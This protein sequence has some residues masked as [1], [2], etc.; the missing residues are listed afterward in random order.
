MVRLRGGTSPSP[1][2][3]SEGDILANVWFRLYSEF[4]SDPKVRTMT[5]SQQLILVRLFCLRCDCPTEKLSDEEIMFGVGCDPSVFQE[6]KRVFLEKG[7]IDEEWTILNWDKRQFFGQKSSA[8]TG[9]PRSRGYVYYVADRSNFVAGRSRIKIGFSSN[10]WA[11]IKELRTAVPGLEILATEAGNFDMEVALHN[12][13]NHLRGEG[14]WFLSTPELM[15]YVAKLRSNYVASTTVA[16]NRTEQ[17]RTEQN[18]TE[19]TFPQTSPK[20]GEFAAVSGVFELPLADKSIYEVPQKLFNEY[21]RAYPGV[22]VMAELGK[23]R[24]WLI[25]NPKKGKTRRGMPAFMN[26][27][28]NTAQNDAS[29]IGGKYNGISTKQSVQD[30]LR[31]LGAE[32]GADRTGG[33][34]AARGA[35]EAGEP[36]THAVVGGTTAKFP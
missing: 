22:S 9:G 19:K 30:V 12:K 20:N 29:K 27:W 8:P 13:F 15:D 4:R 25:S 34:D 7:F 11:R 21:V 23:M 10:P 35:G 16:T 36:A 26:N 31:E 28:L 17:N 5:E 33:S 1:R 14:E 3:P 24:I 32:T 6:A 18:R 2:P